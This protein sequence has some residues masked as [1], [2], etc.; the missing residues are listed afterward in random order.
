M[1]MDDNELSLIK[2]IS[3]WPKIIELSAKHMGPSYLL[4]FD[5]IGIW[6]SFIMEQ[7]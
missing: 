6:I 1:L 3:Q 7:R 4:L 2:L 5:R